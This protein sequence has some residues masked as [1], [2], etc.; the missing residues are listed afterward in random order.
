MLE[1]SD[2]YFKAVIIK[3]INKQLQICSKQIKNWKF[4]ERNRSYK[5]EPDGNFRTETYK[6]WGKKI[7]P[8]IFL[9]GKIILQKWDNS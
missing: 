7:Q 4:Q 1:L 2:K 3:R 9:S 8:R 6:N 5:E